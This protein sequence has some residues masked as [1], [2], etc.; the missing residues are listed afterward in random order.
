MN[1]IMLLW[2]SGSL[3]AFLQIASVTLLTPSFGTSLLAYRLVDVTTV[4]AALVC[5]SGSVDDGIAARSEERRVGSACVSRCSSRWSQNHY[6][7]TKNK[8][9]WLSDAYEITTKLSN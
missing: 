6:K 1:P 3:A 4:V 5:I 2:T 9:T 7:K 8:Y